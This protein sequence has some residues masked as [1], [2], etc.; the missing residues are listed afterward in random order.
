[1]G[2]LMQEQKYPM[3]DF[4]VKKVKCEYLKLQI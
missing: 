4:G 3:G 2:A 1:M